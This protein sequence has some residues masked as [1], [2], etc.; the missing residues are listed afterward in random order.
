ME[1]SRITWPPD[2]LEP[3]ALMRGGVHNDIAL[4]TG[5]DKQMLEPREAPANS[6]ADQRQTVTVPNAAR[7]DDQPQP[8]AQRVDERVLFA[9]LVFLPASKPHGLPA[10]ATLTLWLSIVPALG[11][12]SRS[13]CSRAVMS[14]VVWIVHQPPSCQ[15]RR[16]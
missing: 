14:G 16:K 5:V 11:E 10:S 7:I 3:Q 13:A 8:R 15:N 2:D 4:V 12:P 6:G 9:V 1:A